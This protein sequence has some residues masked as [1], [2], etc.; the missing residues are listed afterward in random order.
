MR[1]L[2]RMMFA[3]VHTASAAKARRMSPDAAYKAVTKQTH[4]RL[5]ILLSDSDFSNAEGQQH[6]ASFDVAARAWDSDNITFVH[7][8]TTHLRPCRS[9][10]AQ[11]S[12]QRTSWW[13]ESG[14]HVTSH[15]LTQ[16][17]PMRFCTFYTFS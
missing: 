15:T 17:P 4:E 6:R 8:F 12:R 3:A 2:T 7:T 14:S 1:L 11:P 13:C 16:C 10:L 9:R 5:F